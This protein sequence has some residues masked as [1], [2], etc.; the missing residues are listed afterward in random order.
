[1]CGKG[2]IIYKAF[3]IE[4]LG[5]G[6]FLALAGW[7]I[8]EAQ[9][10]PITSQPHETVMLQAGEENLRQLKAKR[11]TV[12]ASEELGVSVKK[13]VLG[14]LDQAIRYLELTKQFREQTEEMGRKINQAPARIKEIHALMARPMAAAEDVSKDAA[15]MEIDQLEIRIRREEAD[16]TNA[17]A[18]VAAWSD[19]LE[20]EKNLPQRL[21]E[22]MATAKSRL[23]VLRQEVK[24]SASNGEPAILAEARLSS[25]ISEQN[26]CQAEIK[27]YEQALL[28]NDLMISLYTAELDLASRELSLRED[29]VKAWQ[30][31][32]QKRRQTEA[33]QALKDAEQAKVK[34]SG[35][36]AELQNQFEINIRLGEELESLTAR[37]DALTK[38]LQE[39]Q[40]QLK[41]LEA[42]FSLAK[43]R[44]ETAVL[45]EVI[46]IA[47]LEQR[48][49]LPSPS[50]YRKDSAQRRLEMGK[51]REAQLDVEGK[52]RDLADTDAQERQVSDLLN[53]MTEAGTELLKSRVTKLLSDRRGLLVKLGDGYRRYFKDLQEIEFTEQQLVARAEEYAAFLDKH[54]LW[55][56]TGRTPGIAQ[57]QNIPAAFGW[58]FSPTHWWGLIKNIGTAFGM[59][60]VLWL[61]GV[62]MATLL[63]AG[64]RWAIHDL[65][66]L[67]KKVGRVKSDTFM[68]TLRALLLTFYLA[69]AWPFVMVFTGWRLQEMPIASYFTQAVGSGLKTAG[70]LLAIGGFFYQV[71]RESGLAQAHFKWPNLGRRS[72]RRNLLWLLPALVFLTFI[73]SAMLT[74]DDI[75]QREL[76]AQIAFIL[77]MI[78][79]SS[80]SAWVFRFS[81]DAVSH[82][83]RSHAEGWV[84]RL[85]F[86]WYPLAVGLPLTLGMLDAAGYTYAAIAL[87]YRIRDTFLLFIGL[88]LAY[89]LFLRWLSI[90]GR[91]LA[92]QERQ[93]EIEKAVKGEL[94]QEAEKKSPALGAEGEPITL[95][96][97]ESALIQIDEQTRSL[98][99]TGITFSALLGLWAIWGSLLPALNVLGDV[100]LWTYGADVEGVTKTLPVMLSDVIVG[101]IVAVITVAAAR[102]LPGVL[103]ITLLNRLPID[104]GARYAF[105]T[106]C[107]YAITGLGMI[108]ALSNVG[109]SWST[110]KWLVAAL[111]V[112]LGFGL[113]E[114]VANF[115]CGLI[116]LFE[117][118][119]RVGDMVTVG[120]I[121]GTVTRIRIRATTITDWDRRE[122]IVPNKEFITDRLINWSLS[123][124]ITRIVLPVGIVYGSDTELAEKLLM[125][126]ARENPSVLDHPEPSA[127]FL[128]FGDNSLNF[129]LRVFVEDPLKRFAITHQLHQ[130]IDREFKKAGIVIA[131]P[132]RDVHLD[133]SQPLDIR[134][135]PGQKG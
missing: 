74:W 29:M 3:R 83:A 85:R 59:N 71:G 63:I 102:N 61:L 19:Q 13:G 26:K 35:L 97:T 109:V 11:A 6:L 4:A 46:G 123:D 14:F 118:P 5:I 40:S 93:W 17:R 76:L 70:V 106:I 130:A 120:E 37:Q 127:L 129:E 50:D 43:E 33:V 134:M 47:L 44:V 15:K 56:R 112:G 105:T 122:L 94:T 101:I 62:V 107:R 84:L 75:R 27:T 117:R 99:R 21:R 72:L 125:K 36:P 55:I 12:E 73:T 67:A 87:S 48:A 108:I 77:A 113:Q 103:E 54:L 98:L 100:E 124:P 121:N 82:L 25:L 91:R 80:Y 2:S 79:L 65:E 96:E 28:A 51:I 42:D 88:K 111:G 78:A 69:A 49:S 60:P 34:G 31:Q 1:M 135:V 16:L 10:R 104:R 53:S 81:G 45:T 18:A 64:R 86:V 66:G 23:E 131:F 132:Q 95:K 32:G 133:T 9:E 114:I 20:K 128:E 110:M 89:D 115:V 8:T 24:S 90:E 68:L 52:Y 119:Y 116:V 126:V 57:L 30:A 7:T 92:T 22:D 58:L 41:E 38:N 39:K